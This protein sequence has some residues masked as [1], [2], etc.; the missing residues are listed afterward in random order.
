[1]KIDRASKIIESLCFLAPQ[2]PKPE[3]TGEACGASDATVKHALSLSCNQNGIF[4]VTST[5]VDQHQVLQVPRPS[6]TATGFRS[7]SGSGCCLG[8]NQVLQVWVW[9]L[10]SSAG[11]VAV[12]LTK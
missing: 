5:G 3:R 8:Q 2:T 9:S 12:P 4:V 6:C 7:G 10:S 1:M 11:Q